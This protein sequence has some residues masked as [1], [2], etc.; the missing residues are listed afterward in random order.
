MGH[1]V[2]V[3]R[4]SIAKKIIMAITGL[5]LVGFLVAHLTGN[6]LIF[7]GA[8]AFNTYGYTLTSTPLLYVMEAGL[9]V[10]FFSH[11]GMALKLTIEN[12]LARPQPYYV[13]TK[14]GRGATFASSTMIFT[15]IIIL[16]FCVLHLIHFKYGEH[17]TTVV[18]GK[19]MRDLYKLVMEIFSKPGYVIYYI[20]SM[21]AIAIHLSHGISSSFQSIGFNHP[22]YNCCI[23]KMGIALAILISV[24]FSALPIYCFTQGGF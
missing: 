16:V 18:S 4:T 8:D 21:I 17:Y 6:L 23:R 20:V 10:I 9:L 24:G 15:G 1:L 11:L 7:A 13:R 2:E 22:R 19:E 14:S 5:L 3:L 12:R